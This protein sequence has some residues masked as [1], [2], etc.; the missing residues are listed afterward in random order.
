MPGFPA[1]VNFVNAL[2]RI[3]DIGKSRRYGSSIF[4]SYIA[5]I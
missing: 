4:E 2:I 3:A 1:D 5:G